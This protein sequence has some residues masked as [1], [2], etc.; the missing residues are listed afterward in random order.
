[1]SRPVRRAPDRFA[2]KKPAGPTPRPLRPYP[3]P[4]GGRPPGE[5][6]PGEARQWELILS[7]ELTDRQGE[8]HQR[9]IEVPRSSRGVIYFDSC[10]GSAFIGL[11]LATIIRLRGLKAIGVVTGE[12]S[13]A[14]LMP[15]AA[16]DER[17]ATVHSSL[18]FHP[19]RWQS[20]EQVKLEEAEEWARHFRVM[21]RDQDELL[22]RLFG[23]SVELITT[24]SRPG[25]FV[26][27]ADLAEAG[28]AKLIDLFS[29]DLWV[30]LAALKRAA[31][32]QSPV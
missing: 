25:R 16:C 28:L 10:G 32:S 18:L 31:S 8:L 23:C 19:I 12:C 29:G 1:M 27:G 14:A 9:L 17:Y 22:A 5:F 26:T 4:G 6:E 7:G 30:Q 20:E 11:A 21:E 3:A 13:S 24:W 2:K 15:L